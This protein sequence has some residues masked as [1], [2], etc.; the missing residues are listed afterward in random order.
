MNIDKFKHQHVDILE[1]I[2]ALRRA[3]QAGIAGNATEIARLIVSMSSIIK[4]H[5]AVEDQVLY[6][7]LRN[8]GNATLAKMGKKFQDEM[9]AIATAYM[10]FAGRWNHAA[11]L[12]SDPEGFRADANT[13]LKIL[14]ERMRKENTVFYPAIEAL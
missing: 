9:G 7:A 1:G 10:G 14:H 5:L 13:V 8:G 4:L 11:K 6:P 3:T 2:A 12:T